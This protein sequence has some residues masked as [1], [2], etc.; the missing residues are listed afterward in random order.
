MSHQGTPQ[1][2]DLEKRLNVLEGICSY[3]GLAPA[4][5]LV[6]EAVKVHASELLQ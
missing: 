2:S 1:E 6:I 5:I 4:A 3:L